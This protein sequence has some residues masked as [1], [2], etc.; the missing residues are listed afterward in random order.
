MLMASRLP[1]SGLMSSY[2]DAG[3]SCNE[4]LRLAVAIA[5]EGGRQAAAAR[6]RA[7]IA[8]KGP[9][10]RVT[11]VDMDIQSQLVQHIRACF[12]GDGILA[13]EGVRGDPGDREFVWAVDPLDGT[14]NFALGIPCFA[15]SIGI[16]RNRLPYA[17]VVHDPNTGFTC[18]ATHGQGA[19]MGGQP[20]ALAER[21]LTAASNVAVRVP[22]DPD[23]ADAVT[24][25]LR[26]YKL[27]GFGSVALHLAYAAIGAL[28]IVVD[29]KAALW[30]VAAG[31]VILLEA[32]GTITDPRGQPLFPASAAACRGA[33]MPLLAGNRTAH[34][35]ALADCR[36][37]LRPAEAP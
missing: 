37:C 6:G 12:P 10:D 32:G 23:L 26:R 15:V 27:R 17:G 29:H 18:W 25:W 13:E 8:W 36:A 2:R 33:P 14:N 20:I 1:Q 24:G 35:Q 9:G 22:V 5:H 34:A 31:A 21:P 30:D 19:M 16:L 3:A 7:H 11:D 28:D 4:R